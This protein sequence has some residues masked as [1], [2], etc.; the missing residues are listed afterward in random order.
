MSDMWGSAS[1]RLTPDGSIA[2]TVT[3]G[4]EQGG[5]G[6]L[7]DGR[8]LIVGMTGGKI[9]RIDPQGPVVHAD[10][11]PYTPWGLN[12]M[13]VGPDGTAYVSHFGYDYH[14]GRGSL[15]PT[16]LFRVQ[17][18]GT[19]DQPVNDLHVPN[20]V[21]IAESGEVYVAEPGASRIARLRFG[22][23]GALAERSIFAQLTPRIEGRPAPPDGICL[24]A[25]G[26]V[27]AAEPVGGRVLHFDAAG[28]VDVEW[29]LEGSHPLAVVLAGPDRRDLY[30]CVTGSFDR[31]SMT[32]SPNGRVLLTRVDA[33]GAGV[34]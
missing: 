17:P 16:C 24:D 23:D 27:W 21:A 30:V 19:V 9:W 13:A 5:L 8:M 11:R 33:P 26:G 22:A 10:L 3:V 18:D 4:D 6:W 12:D 1:H 20:G 15:V 25:A 29:T 28:N 34:P 7:P 31:A 32:E 14:G 2:Q